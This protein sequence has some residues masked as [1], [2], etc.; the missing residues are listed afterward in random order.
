[1]LGIGI[2]FGTTNSTLAIFDGAKISYVDIDALS[3]NPSI[4]P[5]ALYL[6]HDYIPTIGTRAI[7]Q[8]LLENEGRQIR[9][10]RQEL[11]EVE[12]SYGE[13]GMHQVAIHAYVDKDMPGQLFHGLKRWLGDPNLGRITVLQEEF[14][15][16]ALI[17][18]ILEHIRLAAE[19]A[20]GEPIHKVHIGRPVNF[21][22]QSTDSNQIALKRLREASENAEIPHARF[23]PEPLA[24]SL[25]Y[26]HG[27]NRNLGDAI[28]TFD[29]GGGTLDL[30]AIELK[31]DGF[32]ILA[33][34]GVTIGGVK[35]DQ[36][37][38]AAKIFP[39]LG[40]GAMV[41]SSP[42]FTTAELPFLSAIR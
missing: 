4:M 34:H 30:S 11:G 9:L 20:L 35:I 6:N 3:L 32:D 15:T 27:K 13:L 23:Y 22:G 42:L 10:T 7:L 29:F 28:V 1:M 8:Y 17:T 31:E 18:P 26:L 2:D 40:K 21:E 19:K 33:T 16:V 14:R 12:I 24:A 41:R 5:T 38:F 36:E 37:V 25:G 39:H